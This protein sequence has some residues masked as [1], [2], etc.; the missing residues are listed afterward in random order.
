MF[1]NTRTETNQNILSNKSD[2]WFHSRLLPSFFIIKSEQR[3]IK[4]KTEGKF[5]D[6]HSSIGCGTEPWTHGVWSSIRL[7]VRF[8]C[9][10]EII[11]AGLLLPDD[12]CRWKE[13]KRKLAMGRVHCWKEAPPWMNSH[14]QLDSP[15]YFPFCTFLNQR[16][17]LILVLE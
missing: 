7:I 8:G 2:K 17:N 1:S 5:H 16:E 14:R 4:N 3:K 9:Q 6:I 12:C 15:S 11:S 13:P 10:Y